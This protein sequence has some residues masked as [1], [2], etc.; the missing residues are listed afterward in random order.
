M[1]LKCRIEDNQAIFK[2]TNDIKTIAMKFDQR[3]DVKKI[4]ALLY[5]ASEI[6]SNCKVEGSKFKEVSGKSIAFR[7]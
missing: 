5:K 2:L 4:E 6:L 3:S 1:V 7:F